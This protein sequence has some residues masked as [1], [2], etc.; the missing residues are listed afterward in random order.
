M[1]TISSSLGMIVCALSDA[2][3]ISGRGPSLLCTYRPSTL[4]SVWGAVPEELAA[5]PCSPGSACVN[6]LPAASPD[7]PSYNI[8]TFICQAGAL[9]IPCIPGTLPGCSAC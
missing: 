4:P 3:C 6:L 8:C 7:L 2:P 9:T 5:L 1:P